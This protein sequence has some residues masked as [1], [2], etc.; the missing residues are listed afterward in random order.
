MTTKLIQG[1]EIDE[2]YIK[3]MNL[4]SSWNNRKWRK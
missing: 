2:K 4:F 1:L 3:I